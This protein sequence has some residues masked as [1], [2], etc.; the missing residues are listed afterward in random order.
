MKI[1]RFISA[2]ALLA[3]LSPAAASGPE[4]PVVRPVLSSCMVEWGSSRLTD[5]Y[6]SPL[7]YSGWHAAFTGERLQAMRFDPERW[8][9]R[10]AGAVN[11]DRTH[12]P[13]RNA[14]MSG[15]TV[16]GEWSMSRRWRLPCRFSAGIGGATGLD[17]GALINSRNGNNPASAIASWH[18]GATGYVAWNGS[19]GRLPVSV[20]YMASL[21]VTGVFF[22]PDYGELYY[23]IWLGD[24]SGLA[25]PIWWGD[26]FRLDNRLTVDLQFGATSLRVGYS[27]RYATSRTSGITSR[28]FRHSIV[29]GIT[30]EWI[31]LNPRHTLTPAARVISATY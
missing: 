12:N 4:M 6:L 18:V 22:S 5:T 20:R 27:G 16:S 15:A 28:T 25:H 3:F 29:I 26:W 19:L 14:T 9:M 1:S 7:R 11:F 21:P 23:E 8:V 17:L 13:A 2:A 30:T 10:L 24:R 31:S